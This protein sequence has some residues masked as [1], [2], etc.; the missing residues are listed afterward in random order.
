MSESLVRVWFCTADVGFGQIVTPALGPAF[1]IRVADD[2]N[3]QEGIDWCDSILLD[4][5]HVGGS[6]EAEKALSS[7]E[8]WRTSE[9]PP[10]V[11][12]I[13]GDDDDL[14]LTRTLI[15]AGAY[16]VVASPLNVA[17]LRFLLLRADRLRRAEKELF[18]ARAQQAA[19]G[20]LDNLIGFSSNMQGTFALA[21]KVASCDV[22]V[23][24]TGETGTGK[25]ML[26]R[27]IHRLSPRSSGPFVSF[28]CPNVQET[29]V[30]DELFGHD[31]GAFTGAFN[32]RRG[33]IETAAGGTLFLD[34]I[35]DLPL[36]L[37]SKLLRVLQE[38]TFERLGSN[39]PLNTN[40][41]FIAAT[42]RKLEEMV[43]QGSFREDLFYRLNVIQLH[44]PPLRERSGAALVLAQ[45]FLQRFSQRFEKNVRR[46]SR[47]ASMAIE[48]Y[49]WPGNVR[50]LENVIQ[51]AVVLADGSAIEIRHLPSHIRSNF[52][53]VPEARVYEKELREFKRRLV[54]RTLRECGGNKAQTARVLGLARGYLHRLVHE[55]DIQS[56]ET[57]QVLP[58]PPAAVESMERELVSKKIM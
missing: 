16:D 45:T 20:C 9:C 53:T 34:E 6:A 18:R 38:R 54:L 14:A 48:E 58:F 2:T 27:T 29:L 12:A 1:Q 25:T 51:R 41:R 47:T 42:N 31:K 3:F 56:T 26:A 22:S 30:E 50:E 17:E 39:T 44:L 4:L 8:Q 28:S 10:P 49:A 7:V 23:L 57:G 13:I 40:A 37:Q 46:L 43:K 24:I 36:P 21:Q 15:A 32:M 33:R 55:L 11:I 52:E 35:G 5:R 19:T